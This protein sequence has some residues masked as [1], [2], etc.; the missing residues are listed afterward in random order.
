[1]RPG[2]VTALAVFNFIFGGLSGLI[3]LVGL[4]AVGMVV[5]QAEQDAKITGQD[6]PSEAFLYATMLFA[7][8]RAALL[9]T[10]GVGYLGRKKFV[11]R[12]LANAYAILALIAIAIEIAFA[13]QTF[14]ILNLVDFVYPLITLFL[15]NVIFR[16]DFK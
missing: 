5:R 16:K 10:A 7:L 3:N 4:A 2:G 6:V 8:V 15:A 14:T 1:M 12:M 9:I 11:G 13:K